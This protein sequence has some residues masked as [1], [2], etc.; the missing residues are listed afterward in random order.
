MKRKA[1]YILLAVIIATGLW[2]YVVTVVNP[3]WEDTFYNIPVVLENEE[4]L[5]ERG[6]MMI[7]DETPKVTLRLTGNRTDMI[8]LN[9][10][11]ITIKA[12]LS[13]IYSAGEQSLSY[14][15]AYPG[16]VPSNAFEVISQTPQQITLSITERKSKNVEVE[17]DFQD[18]TVPEQYIAFKDKAVLDYEKITITGPAEL[19]DRV[20]TAKVKVDLTGKK[21][22]INEK[23]TYTLCDADGNVVE[24]RWITTNT[25]QVNYTLKIQQW[26]EIALRVEVIA[27]GGLTA[28][29][30]E[31]VLKTTTIRVS[32]NESQLADL[33]DELVIGRI[34]LGKILKDETR[35]LPVELPEW[36]TN[37]SGKYTVDVSVKV[38]KE[39]FTTK[40]FQVGQF[41]AA[42]V[43]QG[44]EAVMP[45]EKIT[46]TIRGPKA[47]VNKITEKD[48]LI[49]VFFNNA[50]P[51]ADRYEA[52]VQVTNT[53]LAA[54]VG[55]MDLDP[56]LAQV[57]I[58]GN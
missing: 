7:S 20:V 50:T 23:Y 39:D 55:A 24:S 5:H 22:T 33:G 53:E 51:G 57:K 4:I 48:L 10:S 12:D 49:Q 6:L 35:Q 3:E 15:I 56:V 36:I 40:E 17:M 38:E 18:T 30:C 16:D 37:L 8:K 1:I 42:G 21:E 44:M 47:A 31:I 2:L 46:V 58:I 25:D 9:A 54:Q 26:K 19:V 52:R 14:T 13:R 11:N 27:G 32:G 43:P 41:E 29:N 45:K 34:E 28:E